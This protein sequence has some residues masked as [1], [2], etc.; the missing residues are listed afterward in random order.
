M[1]NPNQIA[2][3]VDNEE[4]NWNNQHPRNSKPLK[5]PCNPVDNEE[6][7]PPMPRAD[8]LVGQ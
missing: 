5:L 3:N 6:R 7:P 8:V 2:I 4:E 1:R